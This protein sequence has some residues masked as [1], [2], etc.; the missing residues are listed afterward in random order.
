MV[1]KQEIIEGLKEAILTYDKKKCVELTKKS[2][3]EKFNPL[4]II[5][6]ALT[7]AIKELGDKFGRGEIA[8]PYLM[9]GAE[10]MQAGLDQLLASIPKGTYKPKATMVLGTVAGDIHDLG[11]SIVSAVF[12][13]NG[14]HIINLGK[15]VPKERFLEAAKEAGADI[16]GTSALLSGTMFQQKVVLEYLKKQGVRD[17][18]I[19]MIG[20]G[21][22]PSGDWCEEIG[23]DGWATDVMVGLEKA[24]SLLKERKGIEI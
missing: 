3:E 13:A 18:Y 23:A 6:E 22:M 4:D 15:D 20:G 17:K 9:V 12:E 1:S 7:P 2:I 24:K 21:A 19:Y 8:L 10:V 16:I 5:Q 11:I 14:I